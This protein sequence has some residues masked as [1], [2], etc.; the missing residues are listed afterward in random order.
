MLLFQHYFE[1]FCIT[2]HFKKCSNCYHCVQCLS[3]LLALITLSK[4]LE[5][6]IF[7]VE[8]YREREKSFYVA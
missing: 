5:F 1:D 8:E 3:K 4:K 7:I 2:V 6:N